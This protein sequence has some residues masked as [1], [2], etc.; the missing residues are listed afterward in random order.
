MALK[1]FGYNLSDRFISTLIQKFD[2]YGNEFEQS[3]NKVF[4][5]FQ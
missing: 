1:S 4:I 2:K 5:L 3:C